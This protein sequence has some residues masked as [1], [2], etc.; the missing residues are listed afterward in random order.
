MHLAPPSRRAL[1]LAAVGAIAM[2]TTVL[3]LGGVASAAPEELP[4]LYFTS[5][6]DSADDTWAWADGEF[7]VPAGYCDIDWLVVG[8]EGGYSTET[9]SAADVTYA[10]EVTGTTA[11][12]AGTYTFSVGG[13]GG[14]GDPVDGGGA[15]GTGGT[16]AQ[17]GDGA[18]VVDGDDTVIGGDGGGGGATTVTGPGGLSISAAGGDGAGVGGGAGGGVTSFQPSDAGLTG[19]VGEWFGTGF[20]SAVVSPCEVVAPVLAPLAPTGLTAEGG[21]G[22]LGV[23]FTP[24]WATD[25]NGTDADSWEYQLGNG[26]WTPVTTTQVEYSADRTFTLTGLTNGSTY[27]VKVRGV[28]QEGGAG[29]ATSAVSG[30]PYAPVGAPGDVA[31]TTTSPSVRVTW[32]AP[33]VAGTFPVAGYVIGMGTGEMG[34][35]VCETAADV[36][37]CVVTGVQSGVDYSVVVFAVDSQGNAG[38]GS[39]AVMTGAIPFPATVPTSNGALGTSGFSTGSVTQGQTITVSGSGYAPFSTVTVLVYSSPTVLGTVEAD[40]NGAFTFTGKLPAGLAAGS[41]TLVAAGVDADGNPRYLTQAITVG[42]P[43]G[44]GGLAYTGADIAV[45]AIGGLAALAVGGGLVL[46][47]RRR[48]AA[49]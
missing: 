41:H 23:R 32:T 22:S 12:P 24:T 40:A 49:E 7:D 5:D 34:G 47:G 31:V 2:S 6:A 30:V 17:G 8:G 35:E 39:D 36:L 48:R 43:T 38:E 27:D 26:A 42:G 33:T 14:A 37:S 19:A 28:S 44:S 10:D 9:D 4:Y 29:A 3:S 13:A 20:V 15:G 46:A 21:N 45:P 25:P 16:G 11:A 18:D 1:G